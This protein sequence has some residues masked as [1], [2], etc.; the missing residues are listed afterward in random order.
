M[1]E[2]MRNSFAPKL[3]VPLGKTSTQ[4]ITLNPSG[5]WKMCSL[6][7]FLR[8]DTNYEYWWCCFSLESLD[9]K[10]LMN[11]KLFQFLDESSQI[12]VLVFDTTWF[13][14]ESQ[15]FSVVEHLIYTWTDDTIDYDGYDT[16]SPA[17]YLLCT[18]NLIRI[19]AKSKLCN[20][21]ELWIF[22]HA[23]DPMID[24][25][26]SIQ[27]SFSKMNA[28]DRCVSEFVLN[29]WQTVKSKQ[30]TGCCLCVCV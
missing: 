12:P 18:I 14:V 15:F 22:L 11:Q 5:R 6:K 7:R 27:F 25:S 23:K 19:Q 13:P 29:T 2:E 4:Y 20:F 10:Q 24:S 21:R 16:R 8:I 1:C 28:C 26:Q 17:A 9:S 3:S 30:N